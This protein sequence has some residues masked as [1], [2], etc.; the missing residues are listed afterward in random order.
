MYLTMFDQSDE[1]AVIVMFFRNLRHKV[2]RQS[3]K[4]KGKKEKKKRKRKERQR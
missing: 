1:T 3:C 4:R 2:L